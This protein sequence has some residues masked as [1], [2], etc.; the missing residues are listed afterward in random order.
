MNQHRQRK[1]PLCLLS[2]PM[3]NL[4]WCLYMQ[5]KKDSCLFVVGLPA[6]WQYRRSI[7]SPLQR[8]Q[9]PKQ[10][11]RPVSKLMHFC[12]SRRQKVAALVYNHYCRRSC[13]YVNSNNLSGARPRLKLRLRCLSSYYCHSPVRGSIKIQ[14]CMHSGAL[15]SCCYHQSKTQRSLYNPRLSL[16]R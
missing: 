1:Q 15:L 11:Y 10:R 4:N 8:V 14:R 9:C 6:P 3:H 2:N 16:L 13:R 12:N 7:L 5:K